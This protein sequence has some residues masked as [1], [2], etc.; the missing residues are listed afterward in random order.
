MSGN[1]CFQENDCY[2]RLPVEK[3]RHYEGKV[4]LRT[5]DWS[6]NQA[7][8]LHAKML[9]VQGT[10]AHGS[11]PFLYVVGGSPNFTPAAFLRSPPDGNAEL[12]IIA[13]LE[14]RRRAIN[15]VE[16]LLGLRD[17]FPRKIDLAELRTIIARPPPGR[18]ERRGWDATCK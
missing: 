16:A 4:E 17:L 9:L 6:S 10:D 7:R 13:R 1:D 8:P 3:I 18:F 5:L 2:T 12:A 11:D 15:S 14:G